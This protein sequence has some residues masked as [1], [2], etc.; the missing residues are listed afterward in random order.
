MTK[1]FS[2]GES[3]FL[4]PSCI[5]YGQSNN[6]PQLER[7]IKFAESGQWANYGN[8]PGGMRYSPAKQ[9]NSGNVKEAETRVDLSIW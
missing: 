9:I 1:K 7:E 6:D 4:F 3:H 5:N 8:D 2:A